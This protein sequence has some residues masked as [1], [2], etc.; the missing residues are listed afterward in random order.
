MSGYRV[1]YGDLQQY[2]DGHIGMGT[3]ARDNDPVLPLFLAE[4]SLPGRMPLQLVLWQ[5]AT[6]P[7]FGSLGEGV[8]ADKCSWAS[9]DAGESCSWVCLNE[10]NQKADLSE[11]PGVNHETCGDSV[12]RQGVYIARL[13]LARVLQHLPSQILWI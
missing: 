6:Q 9:R 5:T 8:R 1:G 7:F 12:F 4:P 13:P 10:L 2:M 3:G 11:N